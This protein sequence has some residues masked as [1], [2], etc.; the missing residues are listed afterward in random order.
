MR[1]DIDLAA[2][3]RV[4]KKLLQYP[5]KP[6]EFAPAVVQHPFTDAGIVAK[7]TETGDY[8]FCNIM[9]DCVERVIW[10]AEKSKLIEAA[11]SAADI[12]CLITK[13]YL[14]TFLDLAKPNL[15]RKVFS[16]MLGDAWVRSEYANEDA[17][18]NTRKLLSWFQQADPKF[19]MDKFEFETLESMPNVVTIYRG[20]TPYNENNVK[21]LSWTA[22]PNT[23]K[24]F[25]N[26]FDQKGTVWK[27]QIAK[28]NIYAYF[29][30]R[31]E[32][33]VIVNPEKLIFEGEKR[34]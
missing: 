5:V 2:L 6:T 27:A 8:D 1:S 22:D 3:K 11:K 32:H 24:W 16:E 12:Y 26:R 29:E 33:E 34:L 7:R 9:T 10:R 30:R 31:G 23:A 17:C 20:V 14:L 15:S 18:V 4:A 25:A 21:A 13:P 28:E 19:L